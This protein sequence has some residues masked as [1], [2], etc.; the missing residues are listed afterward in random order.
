MRSPESAIPTGG[1]DRPRGL[2]DRLY[3]LCKRTGQLL[4]GRPLERQH[5]FVAGV[6][7]SGTNL[8]MQ[9]LDRV[10]VTDVYH[11]T[12]PRAFDRYEMRPQ[13]VIDA[14]VERS[15]APVFVIKSL[16]ELQD[17][18]GLMKRHPPAQTLWM[19]RGYEEVARSMLAS[20]GNFVRQAH[21]LAENREGSDWRGRGMSDATRG[22]LREA[23]A[24]DLDEASAAAL[25]W[26][27]RNVLF[28]EQGF[29]VNPDVRVVRYEALLADPRLECGRIADFLGLPL[30]PKAMAA[31]SRGPG[32]PAGNLAISPLVR[33]CCDDLMHRFGAL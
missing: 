9:V 22:V 8:L 17:L 12:D 4:R 24:H 3:R 28:F 25:M 11:E 16:C 18:D 23:V 1:N 6:Q 33:K 29:D 31:I 27:Y 10:W 32:K 19:L 14:L 26:Y 21:R 30:S 15:R 7:R 2:G 13:P 20:F 5:V